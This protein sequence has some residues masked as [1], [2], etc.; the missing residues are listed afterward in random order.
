MAGLIVDGDDEEE[1]EEQ[2]KESGV[3]FER[4]RR[5]RQSYMKAVRRAPVVPDERV[6]QV[7]MDA[8][9]HRHKVDEKKANRNLVRHWVQDHQSR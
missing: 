9:N 6:K 7:V 2:R 8:A 1:V 3:P 4:F 5:D